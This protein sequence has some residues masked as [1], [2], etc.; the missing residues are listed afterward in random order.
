VSLPGKELR[1]SVGAS[2]ADMNANKKIDISCVLALH[3]EGTIAHNTIKSINR[4]AAYAEGRGLKTELVIVLDRATP[5]TRC[6]VETSPILRTATTRF[7]PVDFG[8]LGLTRNFAIDQSRGQY[9]AILDGDDLIS[10]NWLF[11]AHELNRRDLRFIIHPEVS[12][13]F[14]Q[15]TLLFRHP[16]QRGDNFEESNIIVENYWTA[17]CFSRRDTFLATRYLATP[18]CSGFG[19]EDWHWNCEAM[20]RGFIHTIARRTAHFI[21]SKET[22]SLNAASASRNALIRHSALFDN[23]GARSRRKRRIFGKERLHA[24]KNSLARVRAMTRAAILGPS[25]WD[26]ESYLS[27]NPDVKA[28]IERGEL[29]NGLEHWHRR[30]RLEGRSVG[31]GNGNSG[32]H[33][34][35]SNVPKWLRR[36]ML[37]VSKIEPKLSP[38]KTFCAAAVEHNPMKA[39][40][41][42]QVY[43]QLLGELS[44]K[45]FTHVFLL[46]GAGSANR[47]FLHHIGT[48]STNFGARI[49]AI[50]TEASESG[51]PR[52]HPPKDVAVLHFSRAGAAVDPASAKLVLARLLL[53]LKPAVI[54]NADSA[55]GWQIFCTY[56]AALRSESKLYASLPGFDDRR[57]EEFVAYARELEKVHPYLDGIF[58]DNAEL[59]AK[60]KEIC[61][62]PDELLFVIPPETFADSLIDLTPKPSERSEQHLANRATSHTTSPR[63]ANFPQENPSR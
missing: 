26:E 21:R 8:D 30:G 23:L 47:K 54:H 42:G 55:I 15:K 13:Y 49:L 17:L 34:E 32:R 22:G 41:P 4:A 10:E 52:Q 7:M 6:Y 44:E 24:I 31:N 48:L 11:R 61:G 33:A 3:A 62:I 46:P 38:S 57:E 9:I 58:S 5:E 63:L 25:D 20:A 14:Y 51:S 56:G 39:S 36:E 45:S 60:L 43:M 35:G 18:P 50:F 37:A 27:R 1:A 16:D 29:R 12:V 19:Y 59:P 53:K 40:G 28:A 2:D